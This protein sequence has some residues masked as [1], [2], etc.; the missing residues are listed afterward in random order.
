MNELS[1][2][3]TL[4]DK[5]VED[6]G[7]RQ[8]EYSFSYT[9]QEQDF[10]LEQKG[11][12]VIK[13]TDPLE[14]WKVEEEGLTIEKEVRIDYPNLLYGEQG[15][16]PQDAELG[17]CIMWTNRMLTQTGFILPETDKSLPTGRVCTFC[18]CFEP[19]EL[20][21]DLELSVVFYVKKQAEN[22]KQEEAHLINET[23]VLL[24]EAEV[25]TLNFNSG[26]MEFP[27][28]ECYSKDQ[29]LWWVEF[30][31][32]EDPRDIDLFAKENICVYLNTAY[33]ACPM[34]GENVKNIDL[35][36]QIISTT[37]FLIFQ[38]LKEEDLHATKHDIGLSANS[39]CS[40]MHQFILDCN[41]K[42]G[43][44]WESPEKLLKSIQINVAAILK[45]G[46]D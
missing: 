28:E 42:H 41:A 13:I 31:E 7:Y 32:W 33:D 8:S 26:Y 25:I 5:L 16:V 27:I 37:Y 21:G 18:Y 3:P 2:F 29:P 12:N 45:D 17:I 4:T 43:L 38:R 1:F 15:I 14:I 11:K 44:Q 30:S 20:K 39:I 35:L 46:E 23:G 10:I 22:V 9:Y 40:I 24:G 19:G 34:N 6:C 36:V